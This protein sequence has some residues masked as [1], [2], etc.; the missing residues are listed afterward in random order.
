MLNFLNQRTRES[1]NDNNLENEMERLQTNKLI[2]EKY[3]ATGL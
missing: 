2:A 3:L 1:E